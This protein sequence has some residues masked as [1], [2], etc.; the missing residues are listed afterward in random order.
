[1]DLSAEN[2]PIPE[3]PLNPLG[4]KTLVVDRGKSGCFMLPSEAIA[5]AEEQDQIVIR[6]GIYEDRVVITDRPIYLLG[7]GRDQVTIF[8]RKSGPCYLQRVLGGHISGIT[9]RYVGSDQHSALNILDS[10]CTI[11]HCR[12]TEGILSGIVIYGPQ[13]RPTLRNNEVCRSRESGIFS[14]AGAQPY[15]RDNHCFENHHFG[16][17]VRDASTRPDI[18]HNLCCENM[19][20]GILLFHQAQ[21]LMLNNVCR[22]NAH[23]GM[24]LT[25]DSEPTPNV[26]DL[27]QSNTLE[28]NPHGSLT[29]TAEP[30]AE[31]GR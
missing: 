17:A 25:P 7:D 19:L 18:V 30:L 26:E 10:V 1:M 13:C 31:I 14:F 6:P 2:R 16:I 23:W 15:L 29:I 12:L 21:A 5:K 11:S 9:F 27:P 4:G 22:Q 20:S 28:N 24:V 3:P 8:N